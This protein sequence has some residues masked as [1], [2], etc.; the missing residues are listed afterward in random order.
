MQALFD[1]TIMGFLVWGVTSWLEG[2]GSL[3]SDGSDLVGN[4]VKVGLPAKEKVK[5]LYPELSFDE[6]VSLCEKVPI[7]SLLYHSTL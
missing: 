2:N 5:Q 4:W 6:Q 7:L 1:N 3:H